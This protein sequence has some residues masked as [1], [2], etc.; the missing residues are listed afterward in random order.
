MGKN[1]FDLTGKVAVVTGGTSGIRR[2]NARGLPQAG[3]P[4]RP[5]TPPSASHR[6]GR[7]GPSAT[8]TPSRDRVW[9]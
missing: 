1:I 3:P 7:A 6:R 8:S 4:L 9:P 2:A 5:P